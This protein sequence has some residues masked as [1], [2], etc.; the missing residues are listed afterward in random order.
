MNLRFSEWKIG[1]KFMVA[2][3]LI[4]LILLIVGGFSYR[5]IAHM[6][7]KTK[8]ILRT[9]PLVDASMEMRMAVARDMQMIMELLTAQD[10]TQLEA[11]WLRHDGFVN[12]FNTYAEAILNGA[13]MDGEIIYA[14]EDPKLKTIVNE[15]LS[16]HQDSYQPAV[17]AIYAQVG[18]VF[19]LKRR[20]EKTMAEMEQVFDEINVVADK[21]K[22]KLHDSMQQ[23][24]ERADN[25]QEIFGA[26]YVWSE[27]TMEIKSSIAMSRIFVEEYVQATSDEERSE[28]RKKYETIIG[29]VENWLHAL[30]EGA[31]TRSGSIEK[32]SDPEMR[33]LVATLN[34][35]R[36]QYQ[37]KVLSFMQAARAYVDNN[38]KRQEYEE[39]A[40]N[41]SQQML[42]LLD[43]VE[44]VAKEEIHYA[45]KISGETSARSQI[46]TIS[47]VVIGFVLSFVL[48]LTITRQTVKAIRDIIRQIQGG[49]NNLASA[50]NE[51]SAT[52]QSL[53]QGATEQAAGVEETTASVAQMNA[54]V[55]QNAENSRVTNG[56]A[57]SAAE[58]ARQGGEA[59]ARTVQAMKDI[60]ERIDLI[61]EIAYK[62]NLLSLNAAIEAARAGEHGKGFTVVAAEVRKLAENSRVTAQEIGGLAK[63]SVNVAEE[64]G[65]VLQSMVPNISKTAELVEEITAASAEQSTGIAQINDSMTQLD[66]A[67]QQSAAASEELAATAEELSAQAG[68]LQE[69]VRSFQSMVVSEPTQTDTKSGHLM[70]LDSKKPAEQSVK[71]FERFQ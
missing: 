32:V 22:A 70:Q 52:A 25:A 61:E 58:E 39:T 40:D 64:A 46:Q 5:N 1:T 11:F 23:R 15:A 20:D 62:T 2:I 51:V 69:A 21:F 27:V 36:L 53:S 10:K 33:T 31:Q 30:L 8:E 18:E 71:D 38:A 13:K 67:T 45:A 17:K 34:K 65:R 57:I 47:G 37:E 7:D 44:D 49:A 68:Q 29:R 24:I 19:E 66:K 54:S 56:I 26:E 59:V 12:T 43:S 41:F 14:A 3:S 6:D 42:E 16:Y 4:S 48:G 9:S 60:A 63:N 50:A 28:L 55:Q 35:I